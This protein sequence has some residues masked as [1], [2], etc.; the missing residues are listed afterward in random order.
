MDLQFSRIRK[1]AR[2]MFWPWCAVIFAGVL[3]WLRPYGSQELWLIT[4]NTFLIAIPLLATIPLGMEFQHGTLPLL[5]SQPVARTRIL[6]EKWIV[7]AVAVVSAAIVYAFGRVSPFQDRNTSIIAGIW[8]LTAICSATFWTLVAR[9]TIGG[10]ILNLFQGWGMAFTWQLAR[11]LFRLPPLADKES[12]GD[13]L[14]ATVAALGYALVMLRLSQW[15]LARFQATGSLPGTDVFTGPHIWGSKAPGAVVNLVRKELHLLWLVWLLMIVPILGILGLALL[16]S[17]LGI[18]Y[19]KVATAALLDILTI[20]GIATVLAG[21]LSMGEERTLGTQSGN[22]TLPVSVRLQWL[23]KLAVVIFGSFVGLASAISLAKI[24]F[25]QA[26][27][28]VLLPYDL[29][30][31]GMLKLFM[32]SSILSFAAFWCGC[33][34]KGTV[35]AT[36]LVFPALGAVWWA[37]W[38]GMRAFVQIWLRAETISGGVASMLHPFPF[39]PSTRTMLTQIQIWGLQWFVIPL[40]AV[41]AIQSYRLFRREIQDSVS[42][43]IRQ[44]LPP[45]IAAFLCGLFM[46]FPRVVEASVDGQIYT[47]LLEVSRAIEKMQIDSAKLDAAHPLELTLDEVSR[48]SPLS[49]RLRRWVDG[50][51]ITVTPRVIIR[52]SWRNG[53]PYLATFNYFT[54]VR[55]KNDWNCWVVTSNSFSMGCTSPYGTWGIPTPP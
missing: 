42:F 10:L 3:T 25:G 33:V 55:L 50:T 15:K 43:V 49:D 17:L 20:G 35:R 41:G 34:V 21:S 28:D 26:F 24:A 29:V 23:I 2:A 13:L 36:L 19:E 38:G 31:Y 45:V 30:R 46:P 4:T 47:V 22:M 27:I 5:F 6:R 18:P 53:R 16:Q 51:V 9:S 14:I 8:M 7:M 1:E 39:A 48:T 12:I 52:P 37:Y 11:W 44:M 40:V 54:S 32:A